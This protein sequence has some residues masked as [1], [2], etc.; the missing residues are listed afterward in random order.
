MEYLVGT[1]GWAYFKVPG[2]ESLKAYPQVFNFVEINHTFYE[3]PDSRTVENWRKKVSRDFTFAVRCHQ[4]LTHKIG[5]KS[6]EESYS[7]LARMTE[8]CG[9]LRAPFLVLE[10]PRS[11]VLDN[12]SLGEARDFLSAAK[13]R[14]VQL[15]WDVRAPLTV[16]AACFMQDFG[17]VQSVDLSREQPVE[18]SDVVYSRLFGKGWHN[19]YQFTDDELLEIDAKLQ[20]AQPRIAALA[21]HGMR[22]NTDAARFKLYK[23]TGQFMQVTPFTGA[24]SAKAVLSEDAKFPQSKAEL[25]RL[26]GW[27]VVDLTSE[28][29]VH[30]SDL[31]SKIPEREYTNLDEVVAALE[32]VI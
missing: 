9:I 18:T 8:Y 21:Y 32:A 6:V 2:K 25:V 11:Y 19:R 16:E 20:K 12:K 7:V 1:G 14:D 28:K 22:M 27:K 4:D 29:R 5:L 17:I 23:K 31:L 3:Y 10:T 13:L 30:L 26:Q 24:D 15:V